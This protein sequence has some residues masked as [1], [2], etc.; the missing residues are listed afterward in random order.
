MNT[1]ILRTLEY[2]KIQQALLRQVVTANGQKMVQN[3]TP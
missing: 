1:K 2:D 3:M